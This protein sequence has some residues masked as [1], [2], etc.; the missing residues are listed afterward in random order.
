MK[1]VD[2]AGFFALE[3]PMCKILKIQQTLISWAL[4]LLDSNPW[5]FSCKNI[6]T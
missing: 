2:F 4:L 5:V 3:V 1:N 6:W